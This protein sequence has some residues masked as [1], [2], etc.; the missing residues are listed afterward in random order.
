[1]RKYL[2]LGL[3]GLFAWLPRAKGAGLE[4]SHVSEQG[5]S[6]AQAEQVV[7][8][9][10]MHSAYR[11]W[12]NT[13][14]AYIE[15]NDGEGETFVPGFYMFRLAY[16]LPKAQTTSYA[17][18]YVVSKKTADVWDVSLASACKNLHFPALTRLQTQVMKQTKSTIAGEKA[19]REQFDCVP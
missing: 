16:D 11:K 12:L 10:L 18:P 2:I 4:F 19:L 8:L 14:S 3:L 15:N 9:V 13:S 17:G 1:M 5:L 6:K 7:R